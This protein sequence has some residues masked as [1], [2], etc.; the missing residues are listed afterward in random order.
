MQGTPA[1][2]GAAKRSSNGRTPIEREM[3]SA[4]LDL[5]HTYHF[6]FYHAREFDRLHHTGLDHQN[7]G[8]P[9]RDHARDAAL[10]K[11]RTR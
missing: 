5:L 2:A 4:N 8:A 10:H 9:G 3:R 1:W 6:E 11:A 7:E